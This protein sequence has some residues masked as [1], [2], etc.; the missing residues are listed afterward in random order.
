MASR[1]EGYPSLTARKN[2]GQYATGMLVEAAFILGL[3]VLAYL[4]AVVAMVLWP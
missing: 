4:G 2:W 1:R 3:S